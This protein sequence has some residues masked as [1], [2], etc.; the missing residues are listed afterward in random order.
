VAVKRKIFQEGK[1]YTYDGTDGVYSVVMGEV[2]EGDGYP[3]LSYGDGPPVS[4]SGKKGDIFIDRVNFKLYTRGD[5]NWD[6]GVTFKGATGPQG[7]TGATGTA[8]ALT[9]YLTNETHTVASTAAS[10]AKL[11]GT[12]PLATAGGSIVLLNGTK[13]L[14]EN[15][16]FTM[17]E[18]TSSDATYSWKIKGGTDGSNGLKVRVNKTTGT[19]DVSE[20]GSNAWTSDSETFDIRGTYDGTN[21]IKT[22]KIT[23]S[24]GATIIR[25]VASGQTFRV[26]TDGTAANASSKVYFTA[27]KQ[28]HAGTGSGDVL[29]RVFGV[30]ADGTETDIS[31]GR[32]GPTGSVLTV[33]S[34]SN[35]DKLNANM[36][37]S[38]F[39]TGIKLPAGD[40]YVSLKV[41]AS[42]DGTEDEV[43]LNPVADGAD[44]VTPVSGYLT[45]EVHSVAAYTF[46]NGRINKDELSGTTLVNAGGTFKVLEGTTDKTTSATFS[47]PAQGE[48]SS[49]TSGG[50]AYV[51]KNGLRLEINTSTGVYT[52]KIPSNGVS[53][54]TSQRGEAFTLRATYSGVSVDKIYRIVK[55]KTGEAVVLTPSAFTFNLKPDGTAKNASDLITFKAK[56]SSVKGAKSANDDVTWTV[57]GVQ[58]DGSITSALQSTSTA[59]DGDFLQVIAGDDLT[60]AKMTIA[61]FVTARSSY[62]ALKVRAT[63]DTG[64]FDEVTINPS[65]DGSDG[66]NGADAISGYLTN[67][68]DTVPADADGNVTS[69]AAATGNFIVQQG[70]S[71]VSS[72]IVYRAD[73]AGS[74][75]TQTLNNLKLTINS[76]TGAYSLAET[77]SGAWSSSKET[78]TV[79][80]IYSGVS[81]AVTITKTYKISKAIKGVAGSAGVN[82]NTTLQGIAAPT[83]AVGALNDTFLDT[84]N[85]IIYKKT[86]SS[87]WEVQG[88]T[89]KGATGSKGDGVAT[90]SA[91]M[92]VD[93]TVGLSNSTE[94]KDAEYLILN[95]VI[96]DV[97][98]VVTASDITSGSTVIG[99]K[100]VISSTGNYNIKFINVIKVTGSTSTSVQV[101][102]AIRVAGATNTLTTSDIGSGATVLT[103]FGPAALGSSDISTISSKSNTIS[104]TGGQTTYSVQT[105]E[106]TIKL[107]AGV[108]V[109]FTVDRGSSSNACTVITNTLTGDETGENTIIS[110]TKL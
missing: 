12:T 26:K 41:E 101:I 106:K 110:I 97:G 66:A 96:Q 77:S 104:H 32:V 7:A 17:V 93:N 58:A 60:I 81:P 37:A 55:T 83:G 100:F 22:Y 1:I 89:F 20:T 98:S 70:G 45:N 59:F 82:G 15:V 42:F 43:T 56:I 86:G 48:S 105:H 53:G 76:S 34:T 61:K 14:D 99:R 69:L 5:T 102:S 49:G 103:L 38:Q 94:N 28:G 54:W 95:N 67:E 23:K 24:K 78:F 92:A 19:Y 50:S 47:L 18:Q 108:Q 64:V 11:I 9:G 16:S 6:S 57:Y 4:G 10:P 85:Y 79:R 13:I 62:N 36:T 31:D 109:V 63:Y 51:E 40:D 21:I 27:K 88:T 33:P 75:T 74:G 29:W 73:T 44:G 35:T 46:D 8:S 39:L 90:Y 107:K 30:A 87:T 91:T 72:N 65:F 25:L 68:S 84:T 80:A 2:L 3:L 71:T 52:L